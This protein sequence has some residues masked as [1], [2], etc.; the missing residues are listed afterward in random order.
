VIR[1]LCVLCDLCVA[2]S[3]RAEVALS[4]SSGALRFRDDKRAARAEEMLALHRK[5]GFYFS[6]GGFLRAKALRFCHHECA[7]RELREEA[8]VAP[9]SFLAALYPGVGVRGRLLGECVVDLLC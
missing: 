9:R 2:F 3:R 1:L 5:C 7:A 8:G 4:I 6:I